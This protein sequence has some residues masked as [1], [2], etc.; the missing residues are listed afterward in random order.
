MISLKFNARVRAVKKGEERHT[1]THTHT[2]EYSAATAISVPSLVKIA[3]S[4]WPRSL[5]WRCLSWPV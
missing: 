5:P 1:H 2:P 3:L 4:K